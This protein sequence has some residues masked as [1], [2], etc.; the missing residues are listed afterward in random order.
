MDEVSGV[1]ESG[2]CG[3]LA[4]DTLGIRLLWERAVKP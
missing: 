3:D 1:W 4:R 2:E